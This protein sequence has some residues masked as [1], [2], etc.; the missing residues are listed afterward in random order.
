M[1]ALAS[2]ANRYFRKLPMSTSKQPQVICKQTLVNCTTC[3]KLSRIPSDI[4]PGMLPV[5]LHCPECQAEEMWTVLPSLP[6][7]EPP[8]EQVGYYIVSGVETIEVPMERVPEEYD[9][10][11]AAHDARINTFYGRA[12]QLSGMLR[13]MLELTGTL[14]NDISQFQRNIEDHF[15]DSLRI[16][17]IFGKNYDPGFLQEF[18]VNPFVSVPVH[19]TD[20]LAKEYTRWLIS[21]KFFK[22]DLGVQLHGTGGF[23]LELINSYTRLTRPGTNVLWQYLGVPRNMNLEVY[24]R[25]IIGSDLRFTNND[26]PGIDNDVDHCPEWPS[27]VI[28]DSLSARS[29]LAAHGILGWQKIPMVKDDVYNVNHDMFASHPFMQAAWKR[30]RSCSRFGIFWPRM[31]DA[32]KFSAYA[33][34]LI[35]GIKLVIIGNQDYKVFWQDEIKYGG[36]VMTGSY[37]YAANKEEVGVDVMNKEAT[38]VIVDVSSGVD[39]GRLEALYDYKGKLLVVG[40]DPLMDCEEENEYARLVYGLVSDISYEHANDVTAEWNPKL[41]NPHSELVKSFHKLRRRD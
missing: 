34:S 13:Q 29:W 4:T 14:Q 16:S 25:K 35:K 17:S 31:I 27:V 10:E 1:V 9:E 5:V 32:R 41:M 19:C 2:I 20:K 22:P 15:K 26:I 39:P 40:S 8:K 18:I 11:A 33:S 36:H 38:C 28:E 23:R 12:E 37:V 3:R 21:P 7:V 6:R 24:G 30:F